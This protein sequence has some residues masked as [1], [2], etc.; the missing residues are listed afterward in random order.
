MYRIFCESYRNYINT[1]DKECY[2]LQ[3]AK[4]LELLVD[5]Q[6]YEAEKNKNSEIYKKLCDLLS[7]M[8]NNITK[9]PKFK[10]FLWTIEARNVK[11][12]NYNIT[13]DE[14]LEEQGKLV[15]SFL[16]LAYWY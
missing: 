5:L 10:A 1:F 2:R 14:E 8:Q 11:G 16:Q 6:K 13:E 4:P 12:K 15:N 9:F 7:F 3:I